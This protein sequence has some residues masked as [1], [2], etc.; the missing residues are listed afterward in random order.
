MYFYENMDVSDMFVSCQI[1]IFVVLVILSFVTDIIYIASKEP[2]Y[3]V[4]R[5]AVI[6]VVLK[7]I[8]IVFFLLSLLVDLTQG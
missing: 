2:A 7:I 1:L 6:W 5:Y 4:E 3:V 8:N